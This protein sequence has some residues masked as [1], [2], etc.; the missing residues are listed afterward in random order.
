MTRRHA[1]VDPVTDPHRGTAS[2]HDTAA[3]DPQMPRNEHDAPG[4][5]R[6]EEQDWP[7]VM[8]EYTEERA[9]EYEWLDRLY[10]DSLDPEAYESAH[11]ALLT[12]R[13]MDLPGATPDTAGR[14]HLESL[15]RQVLHLDTEPT[16]DDY[17]HLLSLTANAG[18]ESVTDASALAAHFLVT[19]HG[20]LGNHTV[21]ADGSEYA[22]GRDWTGSRANPP[23]LTKYTVTGP[24]GRPTEHPAPW[25]D[26][27]VVTAQGTP[28][29]LVL[30]AGGRAIHVTDPEEFA[31]LVARDPLRGEGQDIL[32]VVSQGQDHGLA[33]SVAARTGTAVW[34]TDSHVRVT[35]DWET[36]AEHLDLLGGSGGW[37]LL[38]GGEGGLSDL[39]DGLG[40]GHDSAAEDHTAPVSPD[41]A[42]VTHPVAPGH[43]PG[44]PDYA[45][46]LHPPR[47]AGESAL[48]PTDLVDR[49]RARPLTTTDYRV[50]GTTPD[51]VLFEEPTGMYHAAFD[52]R[53]TSSDNVPQLTVPA[54]G[55]R[56][57]L[58]DEHPPLHVSGDLSLAHR[59]YGYG[60]QVFA[61]AKAVEAAN[62]QLSLA[63]SLVRLKAD[64]L[65][66]HVG[67]GKGGHRELVRVTPQFLTRS[68]K[69]EEEVCRDFAQMVSG[70]VPASHVVFR[71]PDGSGVATGPI[72]ALGRTEVTG[73]HYLAE[74]LGQVADGREPTGPM[75]PSWAARQVLRDDRLIAES[76]GPTPGESYGSAL[77]YDPLDNPRRDVLSDAARGIGINEH[78]WAKVGETYLVHSI[79]ALDEN[80]FPSLAHNYAKPSAP[81]GRHFGYH[82]AAVVLASEDGKHQITLENFAR[83]AQ[84]AG[85]MRSVVAENLTRTSPNGFRRLHAA[86]GDELDRQRARGADEATLK[87][88][89]RHLDLVDALTKA[90]DARRAVGATAPGSPQ[91][92]AA[93]AE[94]ERTVKV[95]EARMKQAAD[96]PK[97]SELWHFRMFSQR[98]GETMHEVSADLLSS[99]P[100]A[101]ANPL[102]SVIVHGHRL[103]QVDIGFDQGSRQINKVEARKLT[104]VAEHVVRAGLWNHH[105][106][107]PLPRLTVTGRGTNRR[108]TLGGVFPDSAQVRADTVHRELRDRLDR[109]LINYQHGSAQPHL[110][111]ADFPVRVTTEQGSRTTVSVHDPRQ[112][113]APAAPPTRSRRGPGNTDVQPR[114]P[115][116]PQEPQHPAQPQPPHAAPQESVPQPSYRNERLTIGGVEFADGSSELTGPQRETVHR[117]A[118]EV[119][120]ASLANVRAGFPPPRVEVVG[121]ANGMRDGLPHFGEAL[122]RGQA[123]ADSVAGM[124]RSALAV[125]L[126]RLQ[127]D[128]ET[129]LA[130]EDIEITTRSEG[131]ALPDDSTPNPDPTNTRRHTHI[132]IDLPRPQ[133]DEIS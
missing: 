125:H 46:K 99:T 13:A 29:H 101:E 21:L 100:S 95:A 131:N 70:G 91:E 78:A 130:P 72:N 104:Y 88:L 127:A 105:N 110:T 31:A 107:L 35:T 123:R 34:S 106:G 73:I 22:A 119:A 10:G 63:G 41:H 75:D 112:G 120:W 40:L 76:D 20:A 108:P 84:I 16:E 58:V 30:M 115:R 3:H 97:G 37:A 32:L 77:S 55:M 81:E 124:F 23:D 85:T 39:F 7:R 103:P 50:I 109:H 87:R 47:D 86:V 133:T 36:G 65:A 44:G 54:Q 5:Y 17:R 4:T 14:A 114:A 28:D 45:S 8:E 71:D 2:Q 56:Q 98:P 69:S 93:R 1:W 27:Y 52:Y 68:G 19:E 122:R 83:R 64:G 96:L 12:L 25:H 67:D 59:Q 48:S 89:G 26:P 132:L 42:P 57:T 121:H 24:D 9:R 51:T 111:A 74:A 61:T 18:P 102:T 116:P 33:Q 126:T 82:F 113:D 62:R 66:L 43:D 60:Q 53:R 49:L 90:A 11:G 38:L 118:A 129:V 79:N 80:G 15:A 92:A 128:S 6:D 94:Y 117:L